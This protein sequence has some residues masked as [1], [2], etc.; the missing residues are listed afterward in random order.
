MIYGD[1]TQ[2]FTFFTQCKNPQKKTVA[3][4]AK[5]PG[6]IDSSSTFRCCILD[7]VISYDG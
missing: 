6:K 5:E 3:L 7:G 2:E 1:S 4:T